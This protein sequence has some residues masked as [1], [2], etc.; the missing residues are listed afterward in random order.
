MKRFSLLLLC[1]LLIGVTSARAQLPSFGIGV[2]AGLN[3]PILQADQGNGTV[4]TIKGIFKAPIVRLEP[5]ISFAKYGEPEP[6]IHSEE[7]IPGQEIIVLE[8]SKITSYG[9]NAILGGGMGVPGFSPY[10]LGGVAY[11]KTEREQAPQFDL[12]SKI[13]WSFG[14]GFTISVIPIIE[15]DVRAK[16]NIIPINGASK[17]DANLLAGINYY[18][19]G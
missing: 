10:F 7:F 14:V 5:N 6:F 17:K 9:V 4:F 8:G 15:I 13:G 11:Y 19:G 18:F 2:S 16:V 12:G 3:F 1:L